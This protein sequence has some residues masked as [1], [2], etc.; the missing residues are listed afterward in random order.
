MKVW[1]PHETG[2]ALLG[3]LPPEVTVETMDD[4]ARLP[5]P[6]TDVRFWVPPFL[7]GVDATALLHELPD[8]ALVQLLS[9][10]ADAWVGRVPPG[11]TLCDA[12][13][14]HDPSTAEWVVAAILSQ[15]RSFPALARAQAQ[16]RWAY[17]EVAPTDELAGKRVLIIG[18]GSIGTALR[19]RLT[20]FEVEFTLV[21]RTA[22]PEQQV[23]GVVE[24]PRLLPQADV[25]V[26]LV[27]L[28]EQTRGLVDEQFLA[29]MR[30]GALLVN[31]ARGPV[32]RTDAL[33]A[34]LATGR[35]SAA[36]DV[37]DPEPLPADHPLWEMPNVLMTPH[38]AGS[39]RGL[40]PRAYRLV[41]QQIRRFVAGEPPRNVVV[42]GY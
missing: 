16:R 15:L 37:T 39:V 2:H 21:A 31:A 8:L 38:V 33:V 12:R 3:E 6:V 5:S 18:A 23:H 27:P 32:A 20:P 7:A 41:G 34:E 28:T 1:I 11:V 36:L 24:L 4:P 19:D 10:G 29:A 25:V 14:V 13:G 17:D 22:R 30:D 26:L 40:L 9:A 35:I 42:D